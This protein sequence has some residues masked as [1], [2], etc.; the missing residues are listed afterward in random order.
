MRTRTTLPRGARPHTTTRPR[1]PRSLSRDRARTWT[2]ANWKFDTSFGCPTFLNFGPDY[3]GARDAYDAAIRGKHRAGLA[4][5]A[6]ALAGLIVASRTLSFNATTTGGTFF[7]R[8][9]AFGNRGE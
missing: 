6:A 3:R 4:G 5:F 2:W 1:A 9:F 8:Y 7:L